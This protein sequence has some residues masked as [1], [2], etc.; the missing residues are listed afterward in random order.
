MKNE[1]LDLQEQGNSKNNTSNS[2]HFTLTVYQALYSSA[3]IRITI[4]Q[5]IDTITTIFTWG[6]G[7]SEW[8][9]QGWQGQNLTQTQSHVASE[10]SSHFLINVC[11]PTVIHICR[12]RKNHSQ[13]KGDEEGKVGGGGVVLINYLSHRLVFIRPWTLQPKPIYMPLQ[14]PQLVVEQSARKL[15]YHPI[16]R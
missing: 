12:W 16:F 3:L 15:L 1:G 8:L 11:L 7:S 6:N 9:V 13:G 5:P 14:S 2:Y 4:P 10:Y